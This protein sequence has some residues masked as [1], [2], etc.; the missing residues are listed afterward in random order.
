MDKE[1]LMSD[2]LEP[3]EQPSFP[4]IQEC[5][6][7]M[8]MQANYYPLDYTGISKGKPRKVYFRAVQEGMNKNYRPMIEIFDRVIS[9]TLK[10]AQQ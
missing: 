5:T 9:R 2:T 7:S 8:A 10:E 6:S 1:Q 4:V 3:L